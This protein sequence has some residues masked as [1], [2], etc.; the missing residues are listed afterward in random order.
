MHK[1]YELYICMRCPRCLNEDPAYFYKG[2]KGYYCRKCISFSRICIEDTMEEVSLESPQSHS[3][4]YTL[5]YPLTNEQRR[6]S[7]ICA[8]K[9]EETDVLIHAVTGAGKTELVV[10]TISKMLRMKKKVCFAI[11]RRQVVLE[12][13]E[14]FRTIFPY[15]NVVEVCGGHTSVLDGDLIVCTTHQL[16]RYYNAFDLLILD[17]PDAFPFYGN[18]V[19]HGIASTACTKHH[20]YLTATPDETLL[21]KVNEG[22]LYV[23]NLDE[24]PHKHP[25]PVPRISNHFFIGRIVSL[26]RWIHEFRGTPRMIFMPTIAIA[27]RMYLFLSRFMNV[28][29]CT[30]KTKDRDQ[31]IEDFRNNPEGICICTTVLERGVTIKNVNICIYL[32]D[33]HVFNEAALIQMAGR[34]GR[35][36][37]YPEGDVLLITSKKSEVVDKCIQEIERANK[38]CNV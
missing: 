33:H 21:K 2:I 38:A 24:R 4:E 22:S 35:N 9:I 34:A 5:E 27:K 8:S 16:Y 25:L 19:L 30:S 17:E 29:L 10:E 23:L 20:I 28:Y 31:V 32:A 15:A 6:I 7:A 11:A 1:N 12:L 18:D 36:F 26:I 37:H 13:A 14:R 3:E